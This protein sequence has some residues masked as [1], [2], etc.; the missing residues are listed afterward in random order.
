MAD[1][2]LKRNIGI[3]TTATGA[4]LVVVNVTLRLIGIVQWE[5]NWA[6]GWARYFTEKG[7]P[8]TDVIKVL[9]IVIIVALAIGLLFFAWGELEKRSKL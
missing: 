3:A 8:Y 5:R 6:V 7:L 2:M 4:V 9:N 1:A